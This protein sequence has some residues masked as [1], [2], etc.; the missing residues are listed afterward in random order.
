MDPADHPQQ[1]HS[2]QNHW[3]RID[4]LFYAALDLDPQAR[5]A[6]LQQA[7]GTNVELLKEV[8]SLLESSGKTLGFAGKAILQVAR[9]QTVE[10]QPTGK[11][12]GAYKLLRIIGEGGMGTVYLATRADEM[13]QQEVA[14]KLMHPGFGPS[15]GMLLRF[16]AERQILAN[17]NHPNIARLLD[18]GMTADGLP[19]L[20]ME[21]VNGIAI[22]DYC[23]QNNISVDGRLQL[24]RTVC[25]A[26]EY[27]HKNL[28]VHRDLKP[29]NILVNAE[30]SP[31]L[32]DFGIAKLLDPQ[33]RNL[34]VTRT[35][36]RLMT[37]EYA[38]PEQM[39]G[40]QITT[41][42][43][44]YALGVLLYE[45][46]AGKRPFEMRTK[47][48]LEVAQ[49]I[50][51][52]VPEPPSRAISAS[53]ER[54]AAETARRIR[55]DLDNIVLMAM[56][57]EPS[58]RY[59]SVGALSHDVQAY[60]TGYSVQARTDTWG[61]HAGK[62]VGRHRV[63]VPMAML[64]VVALIGFSV[65]MALL[66]KRADRERR[67][68]DQ[69]RLAAQHEAN[70]LAS[71]FEAATPQITKGNQIT[72]RELLD[73]GAKR[74]DSELA[75]TPDVQ[76]T[77]LY[78]V[79]VAYRQLG[80]TEQA[81]SLL[82]RAYDLRRK[83][84]GEGNLDVAETASAL[85]EV[86]RLEAQYAKAEALYRQA[87]VAAQKA[88]GGNTRVVAEILARLGFC[89]FLDSQDSE[90]ESAL[91]KSLILD[92]GSDY[93]A[94]RQ[95]ELAL[96][97]AYKGDISGSWQM[98]GE[99]LQRLEELAG[100]NSPEFVG[101]SNNRNEVL[102]NMGGNL[103]EAERLQRQTL[104]S[105]RKVSGTH[106]DEAY[107]LDNLG[108]IL[109]AKGDWR[110][111]QPVVWEGLSMRQEQLGEKNPL[112][113]RSLTDWGR[114]LQARGDYTEAG[115]CFRKALD[116]LYETSGPQSW[117]VA[118]GLSDL[119]LLQL[120]RGDYPGA[121]RYARQ[122]LE[123]RRKLGGDEHPDVATSLTEVAVDRELQGDA[124]AA[125]PLLRT[126]LEI[127]KKLPAV[128]HP[129]VIAA[130]TRLGEALT[131]EGKAALAEPILREAV[132]SSH[133]EP[134]P[135][136]AWQIAEPENAL[137]VCLAKLGRTAEAESMLQHSRVPLKS[138]PEPAMQRWMLQR[139]KHE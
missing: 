111:A 97:L 138:Y 5:P 132:N 55:G 127:R 90:A 31:K 116:M 131:D 57:K 120:D 15:Q 79:G 50:C 8:E 41:A 59:T 14:I 105:W 68:A 94:F 121:E 45:L 112:V 85:A 7:C 134:F 24:F 113:A 115:N 66:A 103:L 95:S 60:L 10:P 93:A 122:A 26:V 135:L 92:P 71:I 119:G 30:G 104:A 18:G 65:G 70:F 63:A 80:L 9:Q 91:R 25:A 43:D 35:S 107:A 96:A 75:A 34:A 117:S 27:A 128:G 72:A 47:S 29:A 53:H 76:A 32:L 74:I 2:Q 123:M 37:P 129:A 73:E 99:A 40:D 33:T 78:N 58:R 106:V 1:D 64:A 49:I 102:I 100:P 17:L 19:Y 54:S 110:Q 16:S 114:V 130:E 125:E 87:L 82:E 98:G 22:D 88:P 52:Q 69:Q 20:V 77:M 83:L 4:E 39:R 109:L 139:G 108:H 67:I 136:L 6:F 48:P 84:Y 23:R 81:E 51:E 11:R 13:Y 36:E 21:Y 62:F 137:G 56:R 12:V 44:V 86:Y 124:A 126:A 89:L 46:L 133:V 3:Q 38:S 28:V 42:T 118:N 61:Y 101:A